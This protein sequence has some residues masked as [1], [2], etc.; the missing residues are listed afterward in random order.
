MNPRWEVLKPFEEKKD[1]MNDRISNGIEMY[2]KGY[3]YLTVIV[4]E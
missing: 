1:Y 4:E 2:R 3:A